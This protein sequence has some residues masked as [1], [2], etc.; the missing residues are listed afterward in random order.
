MWY[1]KHVFRWMK[2]PSY[3]QDMRWRCCGAQ[4]LSPGGCTDLCDLCG[5]V[6]GKG[7]PCVLIRHPDSNLQQGMAGYEVHVKTHELVDMN[8]E[9]NK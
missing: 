6:W 3:S 8:M 2:N 5:A 7:P 9:E 1:D 4:E